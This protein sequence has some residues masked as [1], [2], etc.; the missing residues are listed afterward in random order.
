MKQKFIVDGMSCTACSAGVERA[1][2]KLD[3]I[4]RA[5][6]NL[7]AKTLLCEFDETKTTTQDILDAVEDLEF[8]IALVTEAK[9]PVKPAT[10]P[11]QEQFTPI[12]TRLIVSVIFLIILMYISMGHMLHLPLPAFL[13]GMQNAIAF[14]FTQLLLSI[15]IVYVNRKF[16]FSGFKALFKGTANM[17]SLVAIGSSAALIYGVFAIYRIGYGF[18]IGDTEIIHQYMSNL[19]FESACMILALITIGKYLEERS[20]GKTNSAI[21]KLMDLSPK[22]ATV[23]RGGVEI[24]V[25]TQEL[26]VGDIIIIK[27]GEG[28]PVDGT[29]T[30]GGSSVDE[31]ALTG[32]SFPVEKVVGSHVMSASIN[33][34]GSFKMVATRV[35]SDTS[36]AKIIE[37][38][39]D[40]GAT[41]AP[42]ARLADKVA[43]KF[44]PVVITI[45]VLAT[46]V[47]LILGQSIEF[48]LSIGIAV[49]VISCPCALGLATPVAITVA[50]GRSASKGILV[51]TATA[52]ETLHSVDTVVLDKTGTITQG[53]P[54]VT[55]I[56]T[57]NTTEADL[58]SV[59]VSLEKQSEHPLADAII[60]HAK[61]AVVQEVVGF[62]AV[63][64]RGITATIENSPYYAGNL[65]YMQDLNIDTKQ[66][67]TEVDDY[68]N[69]GNTPMYFAKEHSLIGVILASDKVKETSAEAIKTLR[70][71]KIDVIMLTG[72]NEQT[73]NAIA[74]NLELSKVIAQVMP[75]DKEQVV[76]DLQKQ[77]KKVAMVGDG[78]N[79]SIALTRA[80][81]GIA[82]GNGTDIAIE[83]AD[84]VLMKSDLNDVCEAISYSK[85]TLRNIKQNL[86]W[87]FSYNVI[88]IPVAAGVLFPISGH[89][90]SPM[91]AAACMSVSSI[92]VVTNALRLY[93][94]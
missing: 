38:V 70:E 50:T 53:E 71:M 24:S 87:A 22:N 63:A 57:V 26:V 89:T 92:I 79:D 39:Q 16:F 52:L 10:A 67:E 36:L 35:G 27:P 40:A 82:I 66:V 34:T 33:K 47:W 45:S 29:V 72:D 49:L 62:T 48:S 37:L 2:N 93:R 7:L 60:G 58:L 1:V 84:V 31:S 11:T 86:F 59:A 44:V 20:K 69:N 61:T 78:I 30:E 13:T 55:K 8:D 3:G 81:V 65:A 75:Q 41:K 88:G 76:I 83:S 18:G 9:T 68:I 15:P 5:E 77:G 21:S 51:K 19:Y 28:I 94:K 90:L 14:A 32:E 17:D 6:V 80:D 85:K 4:T 12:K 56:I 54:T 73:A 43:G 46:I 23:I 64:G 74:K 25:P 91:I 42:I